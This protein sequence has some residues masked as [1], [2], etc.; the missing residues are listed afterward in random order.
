MYILNISLRWIYFIEWTEKSSSTKCKLTYVR[1]LVFFSFQFF[2]FCPHSETHWI[3]MQL[4]SSTWVFVKLSIKSLF[5]FHTVC[6]DYKRKLHIYSFLLGFNW[7]LFFV[8]YFVRL[9]R[10]WSDLMLT[11]F[12]AG[13]SQHWRQTLSLLYWMLLCTMCDVL[14]LHCV[15]FRIYHQLNTYVNL[16]CDVMKKNWK[17]ILRI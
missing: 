10:C 15:G 12:D 1:Y 4:S 8:D 5:D 14:A 9:L 13:E 16:W 7:I 17:R 11:N 2:F 6:G 3:L